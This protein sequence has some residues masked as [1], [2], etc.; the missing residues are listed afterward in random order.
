MS[1]ILCHTGDLNSH[2]YCAQLFNCTL[3]Q[4]SYPH[5]FLLCKILATAFV[6]T[7][8]HYL[9]H[10]LNCPHNKHRLYCIQCT[11]LCWSRGKSFQWEMKGDMM[12]W[13]GAGQPL[14]LFF[15]QSSLL[16]SV[17]SYCYSH[18]RQFRESVLVCTWLLKSEYHSATSKS[19]V[20]PTAQ[21]SL[22]IYIYNLHHLTS[23]MHVNNYPPP[24]PMH[25]IKLMTARL[26]VCN[27]DTT[28]RLMHWPAL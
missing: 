20:L 25:K 15:H 21:E 19:Q 7:F 28:M 2:Q 18:S 6:N 17:I 23:D 16:C 14:V 24:P 3:Y 22:I 1:T 12:W 9:K 26:R 5:P 10:E 4:L 27:T 13:D 8:T 11:P